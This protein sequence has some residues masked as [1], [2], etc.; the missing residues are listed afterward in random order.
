MNNK[1]K[2]TYLAYFDILGWK[3]IVDKLSDK[4][5]DFLYEQILARTQLAFANGLKLEGVSALPQFSE[6]PVKAITVSDSIVF[7]TDD[8]SENSL[9][10]LLETVSKF[11]SGASLCAYRGCVVYGSVNTILN[12]AGN[13]EG[14]IAHSVSA[15]YGKALINAYEKAEAQEWVGT[16]IDD[17]VINHAK[18]NNF[19]EDTFKRFIEYD[20]PFK[21]RKTNAII[22]KKQLCLDRWL[23]DS[24][25]KTYEE[26]VRELFTLNGLEYNEQTH[27]RKYEYTLEFRKHCNEIKKAAQS[28]KQ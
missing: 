12:W 3:K 4:E 13:K 1:T 15:I 17:S 24:I 22:K 11:A 27:G 26:Q 21:D 23:S 14:E 10:Q 25:D 19:S 8:A 6:S 5:L 28:G 20:V 7:F 16:F 18:E 9:K 2:N